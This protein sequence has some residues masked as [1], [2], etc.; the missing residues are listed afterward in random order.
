VMRW[1][2]DARRSADS[3]RAPIHAAATPS[4]LHLCIPVAAP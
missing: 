4:S 1:L 3:P 2:P